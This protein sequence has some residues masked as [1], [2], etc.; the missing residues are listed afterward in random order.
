MHSSYIYTMCDVN[1]QAPKHPFLWTPGR[2]SK[3]IRAKA[4]PFFHTDWEETLKVEWR[5]RTP[6]LSP[7]EWKEKHA[8]NMNDDW[9]GILM[10]RRYGRRRRLMFRSG[11]YLTIQPDG[12]VK[13]TKQKDSPYGRCLSLS[14]YLSLLHR[15]FYCCC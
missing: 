4:P 5:K 15:A 8:K 12:S 13:G 11:F 2:M 9:S 7:M 10:G 14:L 6:P 1:R 3:H